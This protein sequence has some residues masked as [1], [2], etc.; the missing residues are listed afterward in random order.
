MMSASR[1]SRRRR[2]EPCCATRGRSP[3]TLYVTIFTISRRYPE[4][5]PP[6]PATPRLEREMFRSSRERGRD[7]ENRRPVPPPRR[8]WWGLRV[9]PI[10]VR[11]GPRHSRPMSLPKTPQCYRNLRPNYNTVTN[12]VQRC[13][14]PADELSTFAQAM[15]QMTDL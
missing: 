10:P 5:S 13:L 9:A 7:E 3:F 4:A 15:A 1:A 12:K 11:L 6:G 8:W 2:R 14:W